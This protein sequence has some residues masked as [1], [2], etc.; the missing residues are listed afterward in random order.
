MSGSIFRLGDR[1]DEEASDMERGRREGGKEYTP[2]DVF[3]G[4]ERPLQTLTKVVQ[5]TAMLPSGK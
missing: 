3:V 1:E 5:E 2:Q 4:D